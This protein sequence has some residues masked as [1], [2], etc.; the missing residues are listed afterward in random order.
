MMRWSGL[1]AA[2]AILAASCSRSWVAFQVDADEPIR[3]ATLHLNDRTI[4]LERVGP[5]KYVRVWGGGDADGNIGIVFADGILGSCQV[6]YVASGLD[7][8]KFV[9]KLGNA[10]NCRRASGNIEMT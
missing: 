8:Q 3:S 4:A 10:N 9:I 1:L 2:T 5:G 6:G 7:T